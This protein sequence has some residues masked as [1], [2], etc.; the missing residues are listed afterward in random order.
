ME[1]E[2]RQTALHLSV[3]YSALSAIQI[4]TNYGANVNAVDGSGM[5]PLHMASGMLHKD[6]ITCLIKQGADINM[7][8]VALLVFAGFLF[9]L[10]CV[11]T[12]KQVLL[13]LMNNTC[14]MISQNAVK[15]QK[16]KSD[17]F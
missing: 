16:E 17:R 1:G 3:R 13:K 6:I 12:I 5:T 15:K 14:A 8:C 4:L 7:V 11:L 9:L 10:A 2:S